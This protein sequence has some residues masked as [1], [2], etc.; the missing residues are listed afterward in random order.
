VL[1]LFK[2][3]LIL[4]P[5]VSTAKMNLK[6]SPA[7]E[8]RLKLSKQDV[9]IEI[10]SF[11]NEDIKAIIDPFSFEWV[12][13]D[14]IL[15]IPRVRLKIKISN[16][17]PSFHIEYK[18]VTTSFQQSRKNSYSEL[19][20]SLYEREKVKI[21][22]DNKLVG[23]VKIN[24]LAN[25]ANNT[26]IDYTCSRNGIVING[27]KSEHFSLGCQ[28][29]R[30]GQF[31]KEKPMLEVKWISP[32]LK[33]LGTDTVPYQAAFLNKRPINIK[34]ENVITGERKTLTISARIPK[35]L[36]RM[37]TAYG[38]G[39]YALHTKLTDSKTEEVNTIHTGIAPALFFYLNYKISDST[40]VR[41]FDAAIFQESQFNNA[42]LYLGSDFGFSLDNKLYF[43]TLLGVQY[44]YFKFDENSDEVSE[45]IFPQGL[46]FMYRH[47]FDIPN[48]IISGGIFLS[49][50]D[51]IEYENVWVRWGKNYFWELN[52]I[53]WGKDDFEAKTWGLSV[54]FPFKGFL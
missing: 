30:I 20:Y 13:Y 45:P 16:P 49:T 19:Y 10:V 4:I 42:G 34:V 27:L 26:V 17:D 39:P 3:L 29:R 35:R 32:E 22:K 12:R 18:S 52:L 40:S 5:L 44:L 23:E 8:A 28:T 36:H 24:F 7:G 38:F 46:E 37:F 15:L 11:S 6:N 41:G 54:G 21:F 25:E 47:A 43:T 48:Y 9:K 14:S 50:D 51:D 31:G 33:I 53:S 2:T 1:K